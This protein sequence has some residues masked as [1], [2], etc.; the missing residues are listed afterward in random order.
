[1]RI[2]ALIVALAA[3]SAALASSHFRDRSPGPAISSGR[4]CTP[5]QNGCGFPN[6]TNTG[7]PAGATLKGPTGVT[8]THRVVVNARYATTQKKTSQAESILAEIVEST[9]VPL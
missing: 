3:V 9:P 4:G 7:V 5:V 1:M 6:V 2:L 8:F